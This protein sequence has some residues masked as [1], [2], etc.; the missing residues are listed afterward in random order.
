MNDISVS[1]RV[2]EPPVAPGG[3]LAI[4]CWVHPEQVKAVEEWVQI[5]PF[6]CLA[7]EA[8]VTFALNRPLQ[9]LSPDFEKRLVMVLFPPF[10]QSILS[11]STAAAIL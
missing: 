1:A 3:S 11:E 8:N 10:S 4:H 9:C 2:D 6:V 5:F 7:W